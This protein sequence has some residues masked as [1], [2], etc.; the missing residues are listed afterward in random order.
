MA[1]GANKHI[2]NIAKETTENIKQKVDEEI[3]EKVLTPE[4]IISQLEKELSAK[5]ISE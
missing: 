5:A 1:E 3:N 2:E 4:E